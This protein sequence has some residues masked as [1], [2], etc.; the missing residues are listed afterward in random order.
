MRV[1]PPQACRLFARQCTELTTAKILSARSNEYVNENISATLF[2]C[3]WQGEI[4]AQTISDD[5]FLSFSLMFGDNV[6]DC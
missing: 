4:D 2:I 6:V 1:S 3:L 5:F